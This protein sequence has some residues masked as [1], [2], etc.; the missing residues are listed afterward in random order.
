MSR[1]AFTDDDKTFLR[2]I[3]ANPAELSAWLVYA[4][5]LDEHNDPRAEFIRLEVRRTLLANNDPERTEIEYTLREV[6]KHLDPNWV[7]IFDRPPIENCSPKFPFKCPK[8][9]ENLLATEENTVRHCPICAKQVHYCS[10]IAEAR[11]IADEGHCVAVSLAVFRY[12]GDLALDDS[13]YSD[14]E[15]AERRPTGDSNQ[16][17]QI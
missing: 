15:L 1:P 12:P 17:Y 6:R 4:D 14:E 5:W 11:E 13:E 9:W 16:N 7:T 3:L 10:T 8:Q 2:A